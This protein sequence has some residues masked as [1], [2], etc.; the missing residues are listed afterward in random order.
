MFRTLALV[1]AVLALVCFASAPLLA[2]EEKGDVA[3]GTFV[4]ADGKTLTIKGKDDKEH[5]CEIAADAKVSC[6]GKECK[7]TDL[8]SGF[9]V[10]V[11]IADKKATRIDASSK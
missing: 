7:I 4:K 3:E 10:K 5:S 9:K 1:L 11:T 6:D 8:K 2:Q